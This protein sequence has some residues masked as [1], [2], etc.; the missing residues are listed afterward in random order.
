MN[1]SW[2]THVLA[3]TIW[4][5]ARGES[6]EGRIAVGSVII[7]RLHDKRWPK[8]VAAVCM[9]DQQFSCWNA[10]DPNRAKMLT[11]SDDELQPFYV[12]ASKLIDGTEPDNTEG[13]THYHARNITPSWIEGRLPIIVIDNHAF[14]N[15]VP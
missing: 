3:R 6:N 14:Y 13:S 15:S 2:D 1:L 9:Q 7:N 10:H 12:L 8:T 5:E 11:I 4:G